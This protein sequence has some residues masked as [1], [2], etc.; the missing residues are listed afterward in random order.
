[1]PKLKAGVVGAGIIGKSHV[2]RYMEMRGDVELT[3][4][5]DINEAEAQRVAQ[6]NGIPRVFSDYRDLL[7]VD[8]IDTVDVC[9]PNFLHAP[10]S[11][12]ALEAGKHVYCEK[13]MARTG[14]EAQAMY[15]AAQKA[16]KQLHVQMGTVFTRETKAAKRLIEDGALG[17][18]Y[19]VKTSHGRRKGRVYVDGYATT[20]FVQKEKSGG[21][22]LADTGIYNMARMVYLLDMPEPETASG[23]VFTEIP[24]DEKRRADSGFDVEEF[25]AGVVR[26][27]NDVTMVVEEAWAAFG[28]FD[29]DKLFGSLGGLRL[30]PF[31]LYTDLYGMDANVSFNLDSYERRLRERGQSS[32]G[33]DDSQ[34]HFVWSVLERIEPIDTG[35]IGMIVAQITSALYESA[36]KRAETRF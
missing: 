20:H 24:M 8:E 28:E 18:V 15:E 2:R 21:G 13:P 36:E 1:M 27:K 30:N 33:Y 14:A 4:L 35:R 6:A 17:R 9:L 32:A 11:I 22:T 16:G 12:A 10:V 5:A 23:S 19:Y 31:T 25:A 26:F 3:A 29:G 34:R 7:A